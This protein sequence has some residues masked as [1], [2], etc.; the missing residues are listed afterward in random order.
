MEQL[1]SQRVAFGLLPRF[2]LFNNRYQYP[3]LFYPK[4]PFIVSN[5]V[6]VRDIIGRFGK[7]ERI[8]R[9]FLPDK[10][11]NLLLLFHAKVVTR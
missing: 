2:V 8:I 4:M 10:T 6:K 9:F 7:R 11:D 5:A 1:F 3:F